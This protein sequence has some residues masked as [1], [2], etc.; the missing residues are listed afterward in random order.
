MGY[1]CTIKGGRLKAKDGDS[2]EK[3]KELLRELEIGAEPYP[4]GSLD[5][6]VYDSS[7][8]NYYEES[9]YA[10]AELCKD[11]SYLDFLGEDSQVWSLVVRGGRVVDEPG[12]IEW[13]PEPNKGIVLKLGDGFSLVADSNDMDGYKE[14]YVYLR[15]DSTGIM[16]QDLAV[17]GENYTYGDEGEVKPLHGRYSIKVYSDP[18]NEDWQQEFVIDLTGD[19][20]KIVSAHIGQQLE[21]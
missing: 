10:L 12:V 14:I 2:L 18:D 4:K 1:G 11:G 5:L 7:Y 19:Q 20:P 6:D 16:H 3:L 9:Y 17:V 8:G 21:A 13:R 15:E